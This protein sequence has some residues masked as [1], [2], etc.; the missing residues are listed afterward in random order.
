[1]R[2]SVTKS[3]IL[4]CA[5]LGCSDPAPVA[6]VRA[7]PKSIS[8]AH[9]ECA[10][11]RSTWEMLA[12]LEDLQGSPTVFVHLYHRDR[13]TQRTFDHPI[14]F[15]WQP[16]TR[17]AH[18]FVVCHSELA[19]PIAADPYLLRVGLYDNG[20]G[21]RWPLRIEGE[22]L[23]R[24][25]YALTEVAIQLDSFPSRYTFSG[26]WSDEEGAP[27]DQQHPTSRVLAGEGAVSVEDAP[28]PGYMVTRLQVGDGGATLEHG[29]R[30]QQLTA[31]THLIRTPLA[32]GAAT[33]R[34]QPR[35]APVVLR[36][37]GI[38]RVKG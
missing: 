38:E 37:L 7:E 31:G 6:A 35:S 33:L 5:F 15:P 28:A 10:T 20:S 26:R 24:H 23:A 3:L 27:D 25:A 1:M 2:S 21:E 8:L 13:R 18:S 34:I 22:E 16:Q 17:A 32:H 12:P 14:S 11:V 36:E 30:P 29:N 9:G 19:R 4:A